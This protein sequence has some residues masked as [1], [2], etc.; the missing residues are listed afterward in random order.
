M[1]HARDTIAAIATP[2]GRGG[3]GVI[4]ISG[5]ASGSIAKALLGQHLQPRY[6][7]LANFRNAQGEILDQGLALFFPAPHSYTGE[8]VLELQAHG[9]PVLLD[10]L[11]KCA[12][13]AGARQARAGE[14]TER[15][16][17]NERLDLSQAEA[18]ADLI[19]AASERAVRAARRSLDGQFSEYVHAIIDGLI[20]LRVHIEAGLDFAEEE[21]GV[22]AVGTISESLRAVL[23]QLDCTRRAASCG[24]RL[25]DG[26]KVVIAGAPNAGKSSLLN[27]LCGS[28]SAIVTSQPGTTRDPVSECIIMDGMVLELTDTAGLRESRDAVEKMGIQRAL[29]HTRNADLVLLVFDDH[30]GPG[31][32]GRALCDALPAGGDCL[33]VQNKID[34]SPSTVA[35]LPGVVAISAKTGAGV[36]RL[37]KEILQRA[38]DV[39]A[40][41]EFS[42]RQRHVAALDRA[43][44]ALIRAQALCV[45][46][47][48]MEL[49]ADELR[50]AQQALDEITGRFTSDDLLERIFSSFCLGK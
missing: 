13:S 37:M 20:Q 35:E 7:T 27:R 21:P 31:D 48:G 14:F 8:D 3:I 32:R 46:G 49:L 44:D 28:E 10:L 50:Q 36:D 30:H 19:D 39:A 38:G 43:R 18:V 11:L 16:Y 12:L 1:S 15:A 6:A 29:E 4:R 47:H 22:M 45:A 23:E 33:L 17:L 5:P 26:F 9:G 24:R 25:R 41:G 42:A 40:E 2:P 34:Q